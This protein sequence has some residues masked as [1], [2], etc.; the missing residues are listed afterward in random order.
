MEDDIITE[1][2][3]KYD[4][5]GKSGIKIITKDKMYQ[6]AETFIEQSKGLSGDDNAKYLKDNFTSLWI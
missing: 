4:Q 2:M 1:L 6:A 5:D 3:G